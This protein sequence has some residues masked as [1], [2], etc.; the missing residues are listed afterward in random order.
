MLLL[1]P[2]IDDRSRCIVATHRDAVAPESRFSVQ[3]NSAPP[4]RRSGRRPAYE[5]ALL[6]FA[7]MTFTLFASVPAAAQCPVG[8]VWDDLSRRCRTGSCPEGEMRTADGRCECPSG[9]AR[10]G[11]LCLPSLWVFRPPPPSGCPTNEIRGPNGECVCRD[12]YHRLG[13]TCVASLPSFG[14]PSV[15]PP[16]A[17][18][19]CEY[20]RNADGTCRCPRGQRLRDDGR[21]CGHYACKHSA[22]NPCCPEGKIW[23][24]R[25]RRCMDARLPPRR[26]R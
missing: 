12:G 23:N 25:L 2:A 21:T 17:L 15:P 18:L 4:V 22:R 10:Q 9:Y 20:R 8:Q 26:A 1:L 11:I 14:L 3:Q 16:S 6:G 13:S 5:V 7:C 24:K 19:R